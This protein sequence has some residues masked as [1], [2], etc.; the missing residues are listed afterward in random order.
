MTGPNVV[1]PRGSFRTF[2]YT[3]IDLLS[4]MPRDMRDH[5]AM[6][7]GMDAA[8]PGLWMEFGVFRGDTLTLMAQRH[9]PQLVHGFDSFRGLPEKWRNVTDRNLL[10][11][12]ERGAF[13]MGG[14]PPSL[15]VSNVALHKGW[16]NESLPRFLQDHPEDIAFL[17]ID[18]D[19]YSSAK[20]VLTQCLHQMKNGS[21]LVFDELFN[22]PAYKAGELRAL[23]DVFHGKRYSFELLG[24]SL[25]KVLASPH[26][27][28][29]P[30]AVAM[31]L[32]VAAPSTQL[33]R[34]RG[35]RKNQDGSPE[36]RTRSHSF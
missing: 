19:L 14:R 18:S 22:F 32:L 15:D 35:R 8:P 30:Q 31:R 13:D 3:M 23:Y 7:V 26:S 36:H 21:V 24:H 29:W 5:H 9:A 28:H 16:F 20:L 17:H 34:R 4:N 6:H 2:V 25:D 12:T 33:A 10:K 27:E 11:Y 1:S